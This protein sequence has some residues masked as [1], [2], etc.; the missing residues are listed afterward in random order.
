MR[1]IFKNLTNSKAKKSSLEEII[2][3]LSEIAK[4]REKELQELDK[5]AK[6][7]IRRDLKLSEAVARL[8][9]QRNELD[10]I[11]KLLIRRDFELSQIR[12]GRE[13]EF[14]EL[15]R[16]TEEL[17]KT[18]IALLNILE[19]VEEARKRVEQEKEK[20]LAIITNFSDGLLLFTPQKIL[21]LINPQAEF[22][23]EVSA[24]NV[25][26]KDI[27]ELSKFPNFKP[28]IKVLGKELK[29]VSRKELPIRENLTL[30][31]STITIRGE[32]E[33]IG[34]LVIL[35]DI[36]RE[37]L[38]EKL[39]TE[40]VSLAAHQLRTPLSAIKWTL[41][42]LL[43]G[44]I[45]EISKDQREI[46][47][48]TYKS[49]ERM[50]K[51]INDLLNVTR[52]EE[53]R[54]LY[55]IRVQDVIEI[56]KNV[57]SPLKEEAQ[58]KGLKFELKIE[59]KIP[60]TAIDGEKLSLVLQNLI[61]NSIRYTL[62]G[63]IE[64]SV[65]YLPDKKEIFFSVKDTGIGIPKDQ[66][67]RIFTKFFRAQQA[68][69]LATA[70]SGLGLFISKNIIEAHGGKIWFDSQEG[71]GTTFYFTLPVRRKPKEL[72]EFLKSF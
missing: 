57:S 62:K 15:K 50:I 24:K 71:K 48:K 72:E 1:K 20:T 67:K 17:E 42:M 61:E 46:L 26:E 69:R 53:G 27:L 49:N 21:S 30:E 44:D 45:G 47:E 6:L 52:I 40:F 35:H 7:L 32:R 4:K 5:T 9:R 41:R 37:K 28:L 22:F 58:R 10:R 64:V 18:R 19:D 23:L 33:E 29:R 68:Q 12:E 59:G 60:K 3:Q 54:F 14:Q 13:R 36:T 16:K 38:V 70:G 63:K 65:K 11:A 8:E 56:L 2:A 34:T 66:Q 39:K 31:V 43:D 25:I 55:N 51:L